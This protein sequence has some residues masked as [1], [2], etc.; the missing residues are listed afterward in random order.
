VGLALISGVAVGVFFL[1]LA[2]TS[3]DAGLWPLVVGRSVSV[4]LFGIVAVKSGRRLRL[5]SS[6]VRTAVGC[7]TADM[8]ANALYLIAT[9]YGPLSLVATLASL[10]PAST[11]LLARFTLGERLTRSQ[12]LGVACALV[13][14]MLIVSP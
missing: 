6:V 9:R 1:C 7:G 5:G 10:Y 8:L 14:V 4:P 13:A 3:D 11:V 2:Q 12:A